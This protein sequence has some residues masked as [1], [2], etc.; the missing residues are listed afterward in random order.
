M[1]MC[2]PD[3]APDPFSMSY[4]RTRKNFAPG[5]IGRF[6]GFC[7][8]TVDQDPLGNRPEVDSS[9]PPDGVHEMGAIR[10]DGQ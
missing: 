6:V 2:A 7:V 10:S 9:V 8:P 5:E 1:R 3:P 4:G